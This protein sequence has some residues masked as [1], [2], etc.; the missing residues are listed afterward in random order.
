MLSARGALYEELGRRARAAVLDLRG[1]PG[2]ED[3]LARLAARARRELGDDA[4]LEVDPPDAGGV[5]ARAGS[6]RVDYTLPA[7]AAGCLES[8]GPRLR[9]LWE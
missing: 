1:E 7:L 8:L 9:R 2:Y 3:L 4:V 6:R 5:R